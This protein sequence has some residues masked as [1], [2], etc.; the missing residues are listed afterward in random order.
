MSAEADRPNLLMLSGDRAIGQG[1][2]GP[3]HYTLAGLRRYWNRIDV[4][5]PSAPG[6]SARQPFD[7]VYVHPAAGVRA[8]QPRFIRETG[9]RLAAERR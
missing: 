6:A 5:C 9:R 8:G 4:L 7:N 3:F 1:R 2:Q